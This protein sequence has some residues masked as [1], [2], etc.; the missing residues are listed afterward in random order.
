MSSEATLVPST[1]LPHTKL[2]PLPAAPVS[3]GDS[4]AKDLNEEYWGWE[5]T[6]AENLGP[7]DFVNGL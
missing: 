3:P 5:V 2:E 6:F 1:S 4:C 7:A